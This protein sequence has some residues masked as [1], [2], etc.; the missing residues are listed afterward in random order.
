MKGLGQSVVVLAVVW[1]Q[2]PAAVAQAPAY[3]IEGIP[4][5]GALGGYVAGLG[6]IDG[7]G[8]WDFAVGDEGYSIASDNRGRVVV[9]SGKTGGEIYE[10]FGREGS[11]LGPVA[12]LGDL[13][14]DGVPDFAMGAPLE[15]IDGTVFGRVRIVSG[16][17][18]EVLHV[19]TGREPNA[20]FGKGIANAG[21]VDADGVCDL[22]VG[23]IGA[24]GWLG[25]A[26]VFSGADAS[27]LHVFTGVQ[28]APPIVS[29]GH[30]LA[31]VG[32]VDLDGHDDVAVSA[33]GEGIGGLGSV[34]VYSGSTGALLWTQFG[35]PGWLLGTG[36]ARI[37]TD[38]TDGTPILA[39]GGSGGNTTGFVRIV[40]GDDGAILHTIV[41]P[42]VNS[43]FGLSVAAIGDYDQDGVDDFLVGAP[44]EVV[45]PTGYGAVR[46]YSGADYTELAVISSSVQSSL[47]VAMAGLSD[48][49]GDQ[50]PD[51]VL[52]SSINNQFKQ[53]GFARV[54]LGNCPAPTTYCVG[55]LNSQGCVAQINPMESPS[56]TVG[57]AFRIHA[58]SVVNGQIGLLVWSSASDSVPF[59]GGTLCLA[60][61][62]VRTPPQ[63]SGGSPRPAMDC[64]G[65][66]EFHFTQA[67]MG[68]VSLQAGDFLFCQYWY[69]DPFHQDGLGVGLTD[70][71][72][73]VICP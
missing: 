67:Y 63:V 30:F 62:V 23:A 59:Y 17:D 60:G 6:D 66:Y 31:G 46:V 12:G 69:R 32:D 1:G 25:E 36:L 21:D 16:A 33:W 20:R 51:F 15:Q 40:A 72:M 64:T 48:L 22:L 41:G 43:A 13:D 38:R 49:N 18:G 65:V 28:A 8:A 70:A 53:T 9:I 68:Q 35:E 71:A 50:S 7:D 45:Q 54:Y 2:T 19:L 44:N 37:G 47:G 5:D 39:L 55:K 26:R 57:D 56:L 34:R 11:F 73:S 10:Y 3:T 29:Y 61:P 24:Q 4:G 27:L 52:G 58:K 14:G 42:H